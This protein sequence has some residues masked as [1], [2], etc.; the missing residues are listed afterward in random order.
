VDTGDR[1]AREPTRDGRRRVRQSVHPD[2]RPAQVLERGDGGDELTVRRTARSCNGATASSR[3]PESRT[4][5]LFPA[6]RRAVPRT[7]RDGAATSSRGRPRSVKQLNRRFG[8]SVS[9][10]WRLR[11][12]CR[13]VND[14]NAVRRRSARVP[15]PGGT[16]DEEPSR[17]SRRHVLGLAIAAGGFTV[18]GAVRS[19]FAQSLKRTPA[20]FSALLR[21]PEIGGRTADR[22]LCRG[23]QGVPQAR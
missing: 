5:R 18:S 1:A 8:T 15:D 23:S 12:Q 4:S 2:R 20:R 14:R 17:D 11:C 9:Y 13:P 22:R 3:R 16:L 7:A 21:C 6:Y 19:V 10:D